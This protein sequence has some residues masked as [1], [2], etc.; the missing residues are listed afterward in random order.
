[1]V[2][3]RD[4]RIGYIK[5]YEAVMERQEII[6]KC[7][8]DRDERERLLDA[9][10][11]VSEWVEIYYSWRPNLRDEGDNH[12]IELAVAG[13]VKIV[14]TNNIKD[15]VRSELIFPNIEILTPIQIIN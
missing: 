5:E 4:F 6:D 3:E 9:L 2:D 10:M 12:V 11:S 14:V 13:N 7:R 15:F 1:M 8:L